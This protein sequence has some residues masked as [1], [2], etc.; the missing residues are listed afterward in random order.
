MA[1]GPGAPG[2]TIGRGARR[3]RDD[4]LLMDLEHGRVIVLD[5][6]ARSFVA[7][8]RGQPNVHLSAWLFHHSFPFLV[9]T[10]RIQ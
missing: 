8:R 1:P 7:W 10:A 5:R 2:A 6:S 4:T 3:K 9:E